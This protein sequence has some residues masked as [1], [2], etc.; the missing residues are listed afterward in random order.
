[1]V[2][3]LNINW[4]VYWIT[5]SEMTSKRKCRQCQMT[6]INNNVNYCCYYCVMISNYIFFLITTNNYSKLTNHCANHF[7][8]Y[9]FITPC[10]SVAS[11]YY[12]QVIKML[13][14][15]QW[16]GK[17]VFYDNIKFLKNSSSIVMDEKQK[18]KLCINKRFLSF[19]F[20]KLKCRMYSHHSV[21]V[22]FSDF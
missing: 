16:L 9:L 13:L 17:M 4:I 12:Y 7:D 18:F 15:Y 19:F 11:D 14:R 2:L 21:K 3:F 20:S 5:S 22:L 1:M 8:A 10:A 6:K